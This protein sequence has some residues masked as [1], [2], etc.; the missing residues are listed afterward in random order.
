VVLNRASFALP[1]ALQ[2][3]SKRL[4]SS[5]ALERLEKAEENSTEQDIA[6]LNG[7]HREGR[8]GFVPVKFKEL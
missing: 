3:P 2:I 1:S 8:D 5:Q 6:F 4:T 7:V